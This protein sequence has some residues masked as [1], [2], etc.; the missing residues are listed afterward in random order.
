MNPFLT[1]HL[2]GLAGQLKDYWKGSPQPA[3]SPETFSSPLTPH[4]DLGPVESSPERVPLPPL[5][6]ANTSSY[7]P[8]NAGIR[9]AIESARE[10]LKMTPQQEDRALRRSLLTF[11]DNIRE[12]PK[13]TGFWKNFGSV[14][15]A[16]S[17]AILNHDMAEAQ[18]L[19]ENQE[20]AQQILAY[21]AAEEAKQ[22]AEND[23]LWKR[24]HET[25]KLDETRRYHD[26][27]G[28]AGE[29]TGQTTSDG[30]ENLTGLTLP[31]LIDNT[32]QLIAK[33]PE[34]EERGLTK[35]IFNKFI[36]EGGLR[37]TP[38][39]AEIKT[40]GALIKGNLFKAF[41]YRN[42]AEFE[43]LPN[44]SPDNPKE[45]NLA[46]LHE[47]KRIIQASPGTHPSLSS[48]LSSE[49]KPT[50]SRDTDLGVID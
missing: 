43:N 7:N 23:T 9:A 33:M 14:S 28:T 31:G 16:L 20:L 13:E 34:G 39:Q 30:Q 19:N 10:S 45:V 15:K 40:A 42:Q 44:I 12:Q 27:V 37:L 21:Q 3:P 25:A 48:E 6:V 49:S 24:N 47:L 26:L 35:R 22:S 5:T 11:A 17:P 41:K 50:T 18:S 38:H 36:P 46:I 8:F 4:S 1:N 32:I 29:V 2:F